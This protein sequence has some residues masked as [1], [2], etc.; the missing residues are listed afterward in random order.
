MQYGLMSGLRRLLQNRV[1][2]A[3]EPILGETRPHIQHVLRRNKT[4]DL[5]SSREIM[6]IIAYSRYFP[7]EIL[8]E[9]TT[10]A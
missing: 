1:I 4:K 8:S 3:C 10:Q 7:R 9:G 5:I 2:Q 6:D